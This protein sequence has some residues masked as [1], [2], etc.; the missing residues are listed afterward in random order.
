M[1][2][3]T[4]DAN[5]DGNGE[6]EKKPLRELALAV[7]EKME[8]RD[9]VVVGISSEAEA[10]TALICLLPMFTPRMLSELPYS[11]ID[12][13]A[14]MT[15]LSRLQ[16]RKIVQG[17]RVSTISG[18][19]KVFCLT[20]L[21]AS[22]S[23]IRNAS[24]DLVV[25]QK[26]L[27]ESHSFDEGYLLALYQMIVSRMPWTA[28][29]K[30]LT[31]ENAMKTVLGMRQENIR[32]TTP[33]A[34]CLINGK[35]KD[36]LLYVSPISSSVRPEEIVSELELSYPEI[37][38]SYNGDFSES[39][40]SE[41]RVFICKALAP[42]EPLC[43]KLSAVEKLLSKMQ[44]DNKTIG[45][46]MSDEYS[47]IIE[48]F[49]EYVSQEATKWDRKEL[50]AYVKELDSGRN[51]WHRSYVDKIQYIE[52]RNKYFQLLRSLYKRVADHISGKTKKE[53]QN[54]LNGFVRRLFEGD[55]SVVYTTPSHLEESLGKLHMD[56]I[57]E[58]GKELNKWLKQ[59]FG[60]HRY[61]GDS[62]IIRIPNT[63]FE[64]RFTRS[65]D[66]GQKWKL[67]LLL[68][69]T[70]LC[71][72]LKSAIA[73]YLY[74]D[75]EQIVA[76]SCIVVLIETE[77]SFMQYIAMLQ[78]LFGRLFSM[79]DMHTKDIAGFNIYVKDQD[80]FYVL[81]EQ[82]TF[83]VFDGYNYDP[84]NKEVEEIDGKEAGIQQ[85]V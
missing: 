13:K 27:M 35:K 20:D 69:D 43:F 42:M 48:Q 6:A 41:I 73:L 45:D 54:S 55:H 59:Y 84:E 44:T 37:N 3:I 62:G 80:R 40:I 34:V 18:G 47:E 17:I 85:S 68:V 23:Y 60:K 46:L 30:Y 58:P 9:E 57:R 76:D 63:D 56:T 28:K 74:S 22:G 72:A 11:D 81:K 65:Y 2:E 21:G 77:K 70:D 71:D 15:Y 5:R 50:Q 25:F 8:V 64:M 26:K 67:F 33:L 14:V 1:R 78:R 16:K 61:T 38:L 36:S 52:S 32:P 79:S 53:D 51:H 83:M 4:E 31:D 19:R 66:V 7:A 12:R 10:L 24:E 82:T 75:T 29:T 39:S 49:K